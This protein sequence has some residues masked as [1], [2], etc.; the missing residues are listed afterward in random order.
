MY[1]VDWYTCI[2]G[3]FVCMWCSM[4]LVCVSY[5]SESSDGRMGNPVS[6]GGAEGCPEGLAEG[7]GGVSRG[8]CG[9]A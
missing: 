4:L 8:V 6:C 7:D 2:S 1:K 9:R 5:F 3:M